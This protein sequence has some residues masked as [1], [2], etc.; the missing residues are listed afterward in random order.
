MKRIAV[1]LTLLL[2][3][4]SHA[5]APNRPAE[6]R[7]EVRASQSLFE[8]FAGENEIF[9]S[10]RCT[11]AGYLTIYQIHPDSGLAILYP[12]PQHRWL[13][14]E[15]KQEYRIEKL[16]DDLTLHFDKLEGHVYIGMVITQEPIHLVP[17]LEQAFAAKNI[18]AGQKID[19]VYTDELE[20]V[21][22]KVETDVR[23][24]LAD[25]QTIG[26]ALIPLLIMPRIQTLTEE[27]RDPP[28]PLRYYYAGRYHLVAPDSPN[29]FLPPGRRLHS[30]FVFRR[31][32]PN[33]NTVAPSVS[34]KKPRT[35]QS[36]PP[37]REEKQ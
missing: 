33:T 20:D 14:L 32:Q 17:W 34:N 29:L 21:I 36:Q 19:I 12:Q 1:L 22:E 28:R 9:L 30:P 11:A 25:S 2:P 8:P 23:F 35:N 27:R 18:K 5:A 15:A 6:M 16:A 37:R 7:L 26:F 10:V 13:E 31:S 3:L 4:I 24:R